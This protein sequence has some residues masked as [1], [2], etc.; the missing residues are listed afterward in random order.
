MIPLV[1]SHSGGPVTTTL[2]AVDDSRTMRKVL[3]ITFAGENYRTVLA[4]DSAAALAKLAA[5]KPAVALVDAHLGTDN[6]YDLCQAIKRQSPGVPVIILSSKQQP[7]DRAR[8]T[9]VGADDFVD[10]PF[11]TQQLI[12]KVAAVLRRVSEAPAPA[13]V[14]ARPAAQPPLAAA[15]LQPRPPAQVT[16]RTMAFGSVSAAQP[17]GAPQRPAAP[18]PGPTPGARP[19]VPAALRRPIA[20]T[21]VSGTP[22]QAPQRPAAPA[23]GGTQPSMLSP[24][25]AASRPPAPAARPAPAAPAPP[26]RATAASPPAAAAAP[27]PAAAVSP[28]AAQARPA[29]AA[30]AVQLSGELKDRLRALGLTADQ[31]SG[32]LALS[33]EVVEQVVWEVVP[34]LAETMI[35]EEI[36]RLT[37]E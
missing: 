35:A 32:V 36:K 37:S 1:K 29:Q 6:G 10:K 30:A 22:A 33:R 8:G 26:G 7:Y 21:P 23:V 28:S 14:A 34:V 31:I 19:P 15:G 4:E 11:D 16:A 25:V 27:A 24:G 3:E 2:L 5:E 12:D 20:P 17:P 9:S 18:A 13:P